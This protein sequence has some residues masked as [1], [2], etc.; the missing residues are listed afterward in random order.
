MA[1]LY[2]V[3]SQSDF[4][5]CFKA[6]RAHMGWYVAADGNYFEGMTSRYNNLVN[7]MLL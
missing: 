5:R 4:M 7:K 1:E 2:K 3:L 6:W